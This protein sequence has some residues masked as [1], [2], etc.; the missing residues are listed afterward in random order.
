MRYRRDLQAA[1]D[2]VRSG[3][4]PDDHA[5]AWPDGLDRTLLRGLPIASGARNTLL[6]AGVMIGANGLTTRELLGTPGVGPSTMRHLLVG[7]DEFLREYIERFDGRPRPVDVLV[8]RLEKA[9]ARL[10]PAEAVA[11]EHRL[12][13]RPPTKYHIAAATSGIPSHRIVDGRATARDK[14]T[15]A[16][17]TELESIAAALKVELGPDGAENEVG[18]RIEDLLP[19]NPSDTG[20][21][22]RRILRQTLGNEMGCEFEA[23]AS[24]GEPNEH[25]ARAGAGW[26]CPTCGTHHV[27][28][29]RHGSLGIEG[30]AGRDPRERPGSGPGDSAPG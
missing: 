27:E 18:G 11:T 8:M 26:T 5:L 2:A 3:G 28:V 22:V 29:P 14:L 21:L 20:A 23:D 30:A 24:A 13:R 1:V 9:V 19:R 17:G 4:W 15:I 25:G 16:F 12:L 10:T 7:V 6:R